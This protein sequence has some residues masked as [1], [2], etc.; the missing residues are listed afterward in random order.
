[1][2]ISVK[3]R[4]KVIESYTFDEIRCNSTNEKLINSFDTLEEDIAG[5]FS[6]DVQALGISGGKVSCVKL[7]DEEMLGVVVVVDTK[8]HL[9][10]AEL[11]QLIEEMTKQMGDDGYFGPD[12]LFC[13]V[14]DESKEY[15]VLP[16]HP[17]FE[18]TPI[19]TLQNANV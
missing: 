16:I 11:M 14:E 1:M 19:E 2:A 6:N 8:R 5:C 7:S 13:Y 9:L 18:N 10:K 17:E 12:G 3:Y 15:Y 4:A